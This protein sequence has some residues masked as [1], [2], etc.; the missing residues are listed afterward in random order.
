MSELI[1]QNVRTL[2]RVTLDELWR[3]A[4]AIGCVEVKRSSWSRDCTYDASITFHRKSGTRI[5]AVGKDMDVTVALSMAI[6]EAREM[7]GGT[8]S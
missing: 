2:H 4:E 5:T 3:E 8:P 7:G 6:D 1:N